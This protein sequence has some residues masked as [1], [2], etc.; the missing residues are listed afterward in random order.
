[1]KLKWIAV[2]ALALTLGALPSLGHSQAYGAP[3]PGYQEGQWDAPPQEFR[4][5]ERQGFQDGIQ[6]A[7]RDYNNHR[8][9][10]VA[11]REEYRHPRVDR[12]LRQEY[13]EGFRR[14]YERASQHMVSDRDHD[15]HDHDR[16]D[17]NRDH[18]DPH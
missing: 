3:Q 9:L 17:R 5:A 13:R 7:R 2:P 1:M 6:G 14:G 10:D 16:D 8:Q 12:S 18:D 4:D 11:N 15:H